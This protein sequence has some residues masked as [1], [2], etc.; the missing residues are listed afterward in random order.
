MLPIGLCAENCGGLA[1]G[2]AKSAD[3]RRVIG[4]CDECD[5]CDES[6]EKAEGSNM[7]EESAKTYFEPDATNMIDWGN[8]RGSAALGCAEHL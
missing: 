3:C 6:Q 7:V 2:E 8:S 5:E 1:G 4:F